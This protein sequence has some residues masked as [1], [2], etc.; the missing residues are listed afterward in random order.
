MP[1]LPVPPPDRGRIMT[2]SPTPE[3]KRRHRQV[4]HDSGLLGLAPGP[5]AAEPEQAARDTAS[6]P[7]FGANALTTR[8]LSSL[9]RRLRAK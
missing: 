5:S 1:D 8:Q 4:G 6:G 3:S 2:V 7:L 9:A